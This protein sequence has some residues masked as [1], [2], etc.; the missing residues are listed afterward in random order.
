MII[1]DD[2]MFE[3]RVVIDLRPE[4][5]TC[6]HRPAPHLS[7]VETPRSPSKRAKRRARGKSNGS[8]VSHHG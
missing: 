7:Y 6:Q 2:I 5:T 3:P 4:P 8:E 1:A